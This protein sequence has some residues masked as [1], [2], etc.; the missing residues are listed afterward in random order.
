M[1][2]LS[3][4]SNPVAAAVIAPPPRK[5]SVI[6]VDGFNF[7][8]GLLHQRPELKW[9]NLQRLA[10]LLRPDDDILKVRFFTALLDVGQPVSE[11]RDRQKRLWRALGTQP[12]VELVLGKFAR[13]ERDCLVATCPYRHKF[14]AMEEKQTDVNIALAMVRDIPSFKPQVVVLVSGDIDLLPALEEVTRMDRSIKLVVYIPAPEHELKHRR[15]DEFGKFAAVVKPISEKYL[16]MA[17]FP[18]RVSDGQGGFI[19]RPKAWPEA[20]PPESAIRG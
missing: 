18:A 5:T 3:P 8:Y 10:E 4:P 9:L 19:E 16:R 15:K 2:E 12:K 17:Q 14:W 11:K 1:S 13:R 6:Y 20:P 7:Y